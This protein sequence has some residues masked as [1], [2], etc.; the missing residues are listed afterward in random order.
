MNPESTQG[1]V[2]VNSGNRN[3]PKYQLVVPHA[4]LREAIVTDVTY[5]RR[6]CVDMPM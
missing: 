5:H 3:Q 4:D 1:N 6:L 2:A